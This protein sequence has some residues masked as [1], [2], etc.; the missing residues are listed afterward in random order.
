MTKESIEKMNPI[1]LLS[2]V[3][4]KLRNEF[5]NME[6]LIKYY[7]FSRELIEHKLNEVD[8]FYNKEYN[9]FI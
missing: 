7:D 1:L 8:Y 9:K 3:N 5:E 4:T 2:L 6:D